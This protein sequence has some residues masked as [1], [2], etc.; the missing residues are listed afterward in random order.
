MKKALLILF[1]LS[2]FLYACSGGKTEGEIQMQVLACSEVILGECY[3]GE[4]DAVVDAGFCCDGIWQEE[5]CPAEI[6]ECINKVDISLLGKCYCEDEE[7]VFETGFCCEGVWQ[8]EECP[9]E[10]TECLNGVDVILQGACFCGEVSAVQETGFCCDSVWQEAPC[11]GKVSILPNGDFELMDIKIGPG[12]MFHVNF[13]DHPLLQS[14]FAKTGNYS[15]MFRSEDVKAL[16]NKTWLYNDVIYNINEQCS[17]TLEGWM[18]NDN[19]SKANFSV[20]YWD[21]GCSMFYWDDEYYCSPEEDTCQE[22]YLWGHLGSE[23]PALETWEYHKLVIDFPEWVKHFS[24]RLNNQDDDENGVVYFDGL[25]L[26]ITCTDYTTTLN[27]LLDKETACST[28]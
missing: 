3:C 6:S 14:I 16:D 24:V 10:I 5:A 9:A 13:W 19:V 15:A 27:S 17:I 23:T 22:N 18:Y 26:Y 4:E 8:E 11:P 28:D 21:E 12:E 1:F 2:L 25:N 20:A 7:S